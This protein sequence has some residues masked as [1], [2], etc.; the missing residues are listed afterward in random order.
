LSPSDGEATVF[1]PVERAPRLSD[2]VAAEILST[3]L[4]RGLRVGDRLPSE[5]E[6][7]EQF[8]VSRTVVREA[9]RSLVA[10]GVID[11][12]VGSGLHVAEAN[13]ES[14]TSSMSLFLRIGRTIE[15]EKI[16]EVRAAIETQVAEYAAARATDDE[17]ERLREVCERMAEVLDDIELASDADVAFH[18]ELARAAHN[19]LFGIMLDSIGDI[20]YEIRRSTMDIPGSGAKGLRAHRRIFEGVAAR[21]PSRARQAM[22]KHLD[23]SHREWKKLGR[24]VEWAR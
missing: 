13:P 16:H 5:R 15:Y 21:D 2:T 11:S 1:R 8:G 18:Q 10:R 3:I 12:R 14:V 23:E 22:V 19:E 24:P 17:V 20:L 9:V 6:L 7:G 4:E